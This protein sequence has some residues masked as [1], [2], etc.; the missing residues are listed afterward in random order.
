MGLMR[1]TLINFC[2]DILLGLRG[3]LFLGCFGG[4]EYVPPQWWIVLYGSEVLEVA[5][6]LR[7]FGSVHFFPALLVS[8]LGIMLDFVEMATFYF[9][10]FE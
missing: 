5:R 6:M 2:I 7:W 10:F 1:I 8:G 9:L 4:S 3:I